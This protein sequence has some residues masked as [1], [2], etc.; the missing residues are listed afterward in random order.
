M[1]TESENHAVAGDRGRFRTRSGLLSIGCFGLA[2]RVRP[3]CVLDR[4]QGGRRRPVTLDLGSVAGSVDRTAPTNFG[5]LAIVLGDRT[6]FI[7]GG[8]NLSKRELV[9][10]GTDASDKHFLLGFVEQ[11]RVP[12]SGQ[13]SPRR[14]TDLLPSGCDRRPRALATSSSMPSSVAGA[15]CEA[16]ARHTFDH[17]PGRLVACLAFFSSRFSFNDL[18]DFFD[19]C[20]RGDL[21]AIGCSFGGS[22]HGRG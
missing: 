18:P 6:A 14:L 4:D 20:W 8:L 1:A 9:A 17:E 7:H 15:P 3:V 12:T 21:S 5:L 2:G 22:W 19:W 13:L 10:A 16:P 11:R